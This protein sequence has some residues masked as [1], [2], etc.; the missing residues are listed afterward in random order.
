MKAGWLIVVAALLLAPGLVLAQVTG[1]VRLIQDPRWDGATVN[2]GQ[3]GFWLLPQFRYQKWENSKAWLV[4]P[5]FA[6]SPKGLPALEAGTR[7]FLMNTDPKEGSS[8]TGFS[9]I[10]IWGKYQFLTDPLMLSAGLSFTLP[11]GGEKMVHPWATGEFNFELFGASRYYI[12]DILALVGHLGLRINADAD[13]KIGGNKVKIE[14]ETQFEFGAGIIWQAIEKL[15]LK[16]EL[17]FATEPYKDTDN[18]IEITFAGE[19]FFSDRFSADLGIGI[20]MD[21]AAPDF[22]LILGALILF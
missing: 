19:Y 20:G 8:S 6:W 3:G 14:G 17:N 21:D 4:G 10:D 16:A 22:E 9:D 7:F 18:E 11:T 13:K 5:V 2:S 12:S 15:D 1:D